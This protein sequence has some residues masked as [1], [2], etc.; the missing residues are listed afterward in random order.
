MIPAMIN[1]APTR[2]RFMFQPS[3]GPTDRLEE[4]ESLDVR[5]FANRSASAVTFETTFSEMTPELQQEI[6]RRGNHSALVIQGRPPEAPQCSVG[7]TGD[8]RI[9]PAP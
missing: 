1:V 9:V 7:E 3:E 5:P 2:T 8:A 6:P 4:R